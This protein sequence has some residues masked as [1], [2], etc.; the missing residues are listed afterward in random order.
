SLSAADVHVSVLRPGFAG[1]VHP[2]KL[3]GIMAAGRPTIFIGD[4]ADD[5]ATILAET[6]SGLSVR[7]G[8]AGGLA[9]VIR[10]LRDDHDRTDAMGQRA[11]KAFEERYA[12]PL[13][14]AR[15]QALLQKFA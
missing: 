10:D 8:D 15:W 5:T 9:K 11:R 2:S 3:Y 7:T 4:P 13:A 12:M 6:G 1:L 14:L